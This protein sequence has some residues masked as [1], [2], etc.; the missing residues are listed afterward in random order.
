MVFV[1][2]SVVLGVDLT[3][4]ILP[5]LDFA[6][7]PTNLRI[8]GPHFRQIAKNSTNACKRYYRSSGTT[9]R[10]YNGTTGPA[11]LPPQKQRYYRA[12]GTTGGPGQRY[13][14]PSQNILILIFVWQITSLVLESSSWC[15]NQLPQLIFDDN[16]TARLK[17]TLT[18]PSPQ[19]DHR[20][21]L[22]PLGITCILPC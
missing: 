19:V 3:S 17:C 15:N 4:H 18:P 12:S 2:G 9:A 20:R 1:H 21:H 7:I 16:I 22:T 14:R 10:K 5:S 11:V 13:Y 6:K 8:S